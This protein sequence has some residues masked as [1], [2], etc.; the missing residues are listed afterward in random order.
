M[1][2]YDCIPF[3]NE[4]DI[5][6]LRLNI[7]DPLVDRFV[8]EEAR[9]TFSGMEKELC[10]EKNKDLFKEFLPKIDYIVVDEC[11]EEFTTHERDNFQKNFL[12][13]G[14][15]SA[16]DDDVIILGDAD[17]IPD[18][19]TLKKIIDGFDPDRVYHLVQRLFY[20]YLN[21][22]EV[23]GKLLSI[24]GEFPD[25][26]RLSDR[27]TG[28]GVLITQ[29]AGL[30]NTQ[31]GNNRDANTCLE[32]KMWLG[33][34]VF[35]K[36]NIPADGIIR[37]REIKPEDPRSIRV[38]NGGWHFG[39]MGSHHETDVAKRIGD[40][41]IAAAHQEYNS[42]DYLKEA[43]DRLLLGEDMFRRNSEY[44]RVEI[45]ETFPQYLR[46][47]MDE[48]DYLIMP[49]ISDIQKVFIRTKMN[50]L[51]FFRRLRRYIKRKLA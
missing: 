27:W 23:S 25:E 31:S 39:Y 26:E 30:M 49:K 6:K 21:Y 44:R 15:N 32:H 50:I 40:K 2:V 28:P 19:E 5:L 13:N 11:R 24:T 46:D 36:K 14:L 16:T 37:I 17:E 43:K 48:Y 35:S 9:Y 4:I 47:H 20:C 34:K 29:E 1:M 41:V 33:T 10:F 8:I 42:E 12:I 18:P 45:D 51:R 7:L 3:F 38:P 22:E